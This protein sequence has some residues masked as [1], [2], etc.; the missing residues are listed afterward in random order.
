MTIRDLERIKDREAKKYKRVKEQNDRKFGIQP[1]LSKTKV[2]I[3]ERPVKL[4][5]ISAPTGFLTSAANLTCDR[6]KRNEKCIVSMKAGQKRG[7]DQYWV[8]GRGLKCEDGSEK[9][10]GK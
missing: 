6:P 9:K 8:Y 10:F 4:P 3:P 5:N 2:H 1:G 7:K